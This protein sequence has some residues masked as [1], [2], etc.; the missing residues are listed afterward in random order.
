MNYD[1]ATAID[2]E[3]L[4]FD[5]PAGA[6]LAGYHMADFFTPAGAYK[7]RDQYGVGIAEYER[8]Y[9]TIGSVRGCCGHKHRSLTAAERCR[10]RDANG[11][12]SQGGYSDREVVHVDGTDLTPDEIDSIYGQD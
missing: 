8:R 10:Q 4:T 3:S 6:D 11:C 1:T 12:G 7:G 2:Y 5:A 9:T